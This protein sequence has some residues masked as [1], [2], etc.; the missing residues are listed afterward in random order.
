M[1][2]D[3]CR[4]LMGPSDDPDLGWAINE[5]ES[6]LDPSGLASFIEFKSFGYEAAGRAISEMAILIAAAKTLEDESEFE[7]VAEQCFEDC[8][9]DDPEIRKLRNFYLGFADQI[10]LPPELELISKEV[11]N[12]RIE[13]WSCHYRLLCPDSQNE[14]SGVN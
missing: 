7:R 6:Y 5:Y 2:S 14:S 13:R 8:L 3:N 4:E 1:H 10:A 11:V 9:L 12:E